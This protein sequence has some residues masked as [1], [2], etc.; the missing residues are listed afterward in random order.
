MT[1]MRLPQALP[2]E[3]HL[4]QAFTGTIFTH[5]HWQITWCLTAGHLG[6]SIGC[7]LLAIAFA[8]FLNCGRRK[9]KS[10][11]DC[12]KDGSVRFSAYE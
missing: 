12:A 8:F 1:N 9:V 3:C 11:I 2:G 5:G 6:T 7:V 10:Y 4:S